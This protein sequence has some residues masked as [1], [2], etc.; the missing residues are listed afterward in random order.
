MIVADKVLV[1]IERKSEDEIKGL[2]RE[3]YANK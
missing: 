2:V 3:Y 1:E